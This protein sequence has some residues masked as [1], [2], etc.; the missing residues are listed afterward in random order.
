[1][2][3]L[4]FLCLS[5]ECAVSLLGGTESTKIMFT[6]TTSPIEHGSFELVSLKHLLV[7]VLL[8]ILKYEGV[9][10][11]NAIDRRELINGAQHQTKEK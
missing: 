3:L 8:F 4:N 11:W 6:G 1:M 10:G 2:H 7:S 5:T 9:L